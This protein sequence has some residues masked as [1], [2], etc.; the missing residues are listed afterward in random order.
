[1]DRRR[2]YAA[3]GYSSLFAFCLGELRLTEDA[4]CNHIDA[5]RKSRACPGLLSALADGRI[6]LASIRLLAP[7]LTAETADEMIALATHRSRRELEILLA[8]RFP[9]VEALRLDEGIAALGSFVAP[10]TV[11]APGRIPQAH[12]LSAP[13]RIPPAPPQRIEPLS[14]QRYSIQV[15]VSKA[16]HDKIRQAQALLRH[17]NPSGD[18]AIVL[19]H[20]ADAFLLQKQ[21]RKQAATQRPQ[22]KLRS[23][24]SPRH[25]SARVR[26]AVWE[27]DAGRCTFV[28]DTGHRCGACEFLEFDHVT[29]V[30]RGGSPSVEGMRLRCRTHNQL[31]AE[32][33]FGRA[34]MEARRVGKLGATEFKDPRAAP[35]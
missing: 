14:A 17:A 33:V 2:L 3:A 5:A 23:S 35:T 32:R 18:L 31:E 34:F 7:H 29:P 13:G 10:E 24:N 15:T 9:K 16:T 26:R 27:R 6:H 8:A 12:P 22:A 4:A 30:A 21:K 19:D 1:M 25:V 28:G 20:M 11:S